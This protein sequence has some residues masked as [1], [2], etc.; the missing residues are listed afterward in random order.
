MTDQEFSLLY[1]NLELKEY[2]SKIIAAKTKNIEF[3]EDLLQEIWGMVSHSSSGQSLSFYKH[4]AYKVVD[5]FFHREWREWQY[6]KK[7]V[8]GGHY[9][10]KEANLFSSWDEEDDWH[11]IPPET[12]TKEERREE[13]NMRKRVGRVLKKYQ[14]K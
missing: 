6:R 7:Y 3:R 4:E 11:D 2:L 9:P 14:K 5:K 13:Y 1:N 12:M 8:K 10:Q